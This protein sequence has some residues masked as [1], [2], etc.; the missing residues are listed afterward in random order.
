MQYLAKVDF[1]FSRSLG[2]CPYPRPQDSSAPTGSSRSSST[3]K[4]P[5]LRDFHSLIGRAIFIRYLEDRD[6][7]LPAYFESIA[8]RRKE[9]TKLL[10]QSPTAPSLEPRLAEL[11]FVRVL[12][13]KAFTYALSEQLAADFNGDIFPIEEEERSGFNRCISMRSEAFCLAR[14]PLRAWPKKE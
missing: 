14:L 4:R 11:R 10:A 8:A 5:A 3:C 1:R 12:Q 2:S 6:I 9:W 13:N 7:L